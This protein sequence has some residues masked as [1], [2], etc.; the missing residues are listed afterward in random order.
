MVGMAGCAGPF[1][2]LQEMT[3]T[4]MIALMISLLSVLA[5]MHFSKIDSDVFGVYQFVV[6]ISTL[7]VRW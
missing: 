6:F 7:R 3:V 1:F 4:A 5:G 2:G